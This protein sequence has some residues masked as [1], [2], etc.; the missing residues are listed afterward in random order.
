VSDVLP[1]GDRTAPLKVWRGAAGEEGRFQAYDVPFEE[2]M[3]VLDALRWIRT[4]VDPGL[5]IRYS[6]INAN[7]CHTCMALVDGV[8][9][10]TCTARLRAAGATVA[11]L[12]KRPVIRDLVTDTLPPEERL[13]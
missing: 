12:P 10:Y 6:C 1:S 4:H 13:L 11:P 8:V 9:E 2:G 3:S 7:A 5:A